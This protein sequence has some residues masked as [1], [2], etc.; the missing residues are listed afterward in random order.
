MI[1]FIAGLSIGIL[2][3]MFIII[4]LAIVLGKENK[5]E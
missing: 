4:D 2:I 1:Y 5:D 3:G